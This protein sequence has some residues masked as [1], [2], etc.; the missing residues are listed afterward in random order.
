MSLTQLLLPINVPG[1]AASDLAAEL[2]KFDA[3]G[4][5]TNVSSLKTPDAP[6]VPVFTNEFWTSR[7]R[8][9]HSL[10]EISYRACFKPQLPGFFINR[11][12]S[13][14]DVV[15]DPFL[16]RGT[17]LLEAALLGRTPWGCD[18]NPLC[19]LLIAPRLAPPSEKEIQEWLDAYRPPALREP[20]P[21]DLLVFYH[22]DVLQELAAL[23]QHFL[24]ADARGGCSPIEAW[25]RMVAT[26]RLTGHSAG[27]FSVYSLPPNQAVSVQ[28]QRRINEKRNQQ[29]PP[30][31]FRK[32]LL[33]KSRSLL[34]DLNADERRS[35]GKS[36]AKAR[37]L[38]ASCD[39]TPA[40]RSN[41]VDLV[42]TSPPFL[43]E[44]QY[45]T[46]NWL[47]CWF[48]GIDA[49]SIELF[50]LRRPDQWQAKMRDVL[51]ELHRVLKPGGHIAFE[52][53]EVFSGSLGLEELILPA[54]CQAGLAP[55]LVLIN[56]QEFTKTSNCWGV[57]NQELGTN[58]NRIVLF[59]KP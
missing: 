29:P 22:P 30:R 43:S 21:E 41:S 28:S 53:G 9:A 38:T 55:E 36:A 52:V 32:I 26:N 54:G 24:D 10:H 44:V 13:P 11:L 46:D 27:Y 7:Q 23:R 59:R 35:L 14:G 2:A 6:E 57:T 16:G 56:S 4:T 20:P 5:T 3:F 31:D 1:A 45:K 33:K 48:N 19:A 15:Y 51:V 39:S 42:V 34:K 58:S 17:T 50:M 40:L 47:R 12:T 18:L 8:Q 37:I 49:D 25:M